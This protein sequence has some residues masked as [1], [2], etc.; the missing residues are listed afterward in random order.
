MLKAAAILN[1]LLITLLIATF[2]GVTILF[3][4]YHNLQIDQNISNNEL[5]DHHSSCLN[6]YKANDLKYQLETAD[7]DVRCSVKKEKWGFFEVAQVT[8]TKN[9]DLLTKSYL[10]SK[11]LLNPPLLYLSDHKELLKVSGKTSLK[12]NLFIPKGRIEQSNILGNSVS[13]SLDIR[14]AFFPSKEKLPTIESIQYLDKR[15]LEISL[16][17]II[18]NS[19]NYNAFISKPTYL[20]PIDGNIVLENIKLKGNFRLNINGTCIIKKSAVLEDII[21]NAN[22]IIVDRGFEGTVQLFSTKIEI[23]EDV[24]F[25]FP[26]VIYLKE[27]QSEDGT[28]HETFFSRK[29]KLHGAFILQSTNAKRT[30]LT[31]EK[32]AEIKGMIY[33]NGYLD[34]KGSVKGSIFTDYLRLKTQYSNYTN[35][36]LNQHIDTLSYHN[37][38]VN[39]GGLKL[40]SSVSSNMIIKVL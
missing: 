15:S 36:I 8:S 19:I 31:I 18:D 37:K 21:I 14:S 32:D 23:K 4:F 29:A 17:E 27:Q 40:S 3:C 9:K 20:V 24:T 35:L 5:V 22:E 7:L 30:L 16:D 39:Y 38:S 10:T 28:I 2:C 33:C 13:N 11:T 12:G 34:I 26:S 25:R 1:A 6:N